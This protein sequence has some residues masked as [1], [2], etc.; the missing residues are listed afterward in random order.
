ML[1]YLNH[2]L[3]T[4][5]RVNYVSMSEAIALELSYGADCYLKPVKHPTQLLYSNRQCV[6]NEGR[7]YNHS[8]CHYTKREKLC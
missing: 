1:L 4:N 5:G 6:H 2:C 3:Q 7:Q 8:K